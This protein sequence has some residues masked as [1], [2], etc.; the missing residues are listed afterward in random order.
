MK[1][2]REETSR[3]I[4]FGSIGVHSWFEY[5]GFLYK[6]DNTISGSHIEQMTGQTFDASCP[7]QPVEIIEIRY[8][9]KY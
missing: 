7:V 6:K 8:K 5:G 1:I 2:T 9:P 3:T 4:V